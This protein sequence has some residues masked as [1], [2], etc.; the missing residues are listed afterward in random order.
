MLR[1][2]DPRFKR[3]TRHS[4]N[5]KFMESRIFYRNISGHW[6]P[7]G[8]RK[9]LPHR[10][11]FQRPND[12]NSWRVIYERLSPVSHSHHRIAPSCL[13]HW[14]SFLPAPR[15]TSLLYIN[16][17]QWKHPLLINSIK[18]LLARSNFTG[19][20]LSNNIPPPTIPQ[21]T[22]PHYWKWTAPAVT[23]S[24][25]ILALEINLTTQNLKSNYPSN[26]FKFSHLLGYFPTLMHCLSPYLN[27]SVSQKSAS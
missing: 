24:G 23:V 1:I 19:F 9:T 4:N 6:K 5:R 18:Y 2:H 3:W 11:S 10:F 17:H 15:A 20:V 16:Y 27:L 22:M 14:N 26:L 13:Q 8:N 7:R 21:I 25:F 12:G